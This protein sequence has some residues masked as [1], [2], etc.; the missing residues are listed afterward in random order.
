MRK[1]FICLESYHKIKYN[2]ECTLGPILLA[3][4]AP[5]D[6]ILGFARFNLFFWSPLSQ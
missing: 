2:W 6:V 1:D 4:V 5:A 3:D